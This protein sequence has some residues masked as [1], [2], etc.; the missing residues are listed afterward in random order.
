MRQSAGASRSTSSPSSGS[1]RPPRSTST[2]SSR[3]TTSSRHADHDREGRG[4]TGPELRAAARRCVQASTST[5]TPEDRA[6]SAQTPSSERPRRCS[7]RCRRRLGGVRHQSGRA[8]VSVSDGRRP[9]RPARFRKAPNSSPVRK[10]S[11]QPFWL[12]ASF[13][14][15]ESCISV[16]QVGQRLL[17][18]VAEAGRG[19][20]AAPVGELHVHAGLLAASARRRRAP[21]GAGHREHPQL[22]GLDLLGELADARDAEGDL[23]A[24]QRVEQLAAAVVARCS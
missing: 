17:V 22:A 4:P 3:R 10:A 1:P 8:P 14:S 16:D 9:A 12:T 19:D 7:A 23:A 20:D 15:C 5:S 24:E 11:V 21:L 18:G 6:G 13:H 2:A